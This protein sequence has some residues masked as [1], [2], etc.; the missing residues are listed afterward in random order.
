MYTNISPAYTDVHTHGHALHTHLM[1]NFIAINAWTALVRRCG[2]TS[3]CQ[4]KQSLQFGAAST[5][6]NALELTC[7]L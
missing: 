2:N 7:S 1:T 5:V 3:V 6:E 4:Q